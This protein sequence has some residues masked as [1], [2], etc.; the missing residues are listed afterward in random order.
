MTSRTRFG[1]TRALAFILIYLFQLIGGIVFLI[2]DRDDRE[3]RFHSLMS[4]Y[5]CLAQIVVTLLLNLLRAIPFIGWMFTIFLWLVTIAYI[6]T[7][8]LSMIR[9]LNGTR[10]KVPFF[11]HLADRRA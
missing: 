11:Y 4:C 7:M 3:I 2:T 6:C 1:V 9:A 10:L 8:L 5:L